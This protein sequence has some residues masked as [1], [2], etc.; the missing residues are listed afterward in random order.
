MIAPNAPRAASWIPAARPRRLLASGVLVVAAVAASGCSSGGGEARLASTGEKYFGDVTPPAGQVFTYNNGAEPQTTDPALMTGQ[1]DGRI[2]RIMFEGLTTPDPETLEPLPGQ[3]YRWEMS[4]DGLVYTFHM[5]QGLRWSDGTP[6]DARDFVWSWFRVLAPATASRYASVL[7]PIKNAER[8]NKGEVDATQVGIA[9]PDDSTLVVT[10]Q[11]PTPYFLFLTQFYTYLPTPKHVVEKH[12]DRWTQPQNVAGNGPFN[13]TFWRQRDRFEFVKNPGYWD[14]ANVKLDRLIVFCVEDLNTSTNLYKAG[15]IDWNPSGYIPSQFIPYM[16]QFADYR[17]GP[18]QGTYFYSV[19]VTAPPLDNRWVRKALNHAIDREAISRD[20][21][22]SSRDPWGNWPPSGYPGYE[23]P[24][25]VTYDPDY[26]RECLAK[27]GYPGGKGM[28]KITILFNTSEDHRRIAEAIQIMW[29]EVLG[30][31]VELE[32]K[33]WGSY[34]S[35]CF[36][37]KYDVARRSWIGDY[38]DPNTFMQCFATGDGNNRTGWGDPRY[39]GLLRK[40]AF[41]LDPPARMKLMAQAEAILLDESPVLPIYHYS[42]N[43][44]V[45]PYVR[46]IHRT[47]LDTHPMKSVWID[48][49]WRAREAELA[50]GE[51]PR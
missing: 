27:A 24:P 40:A 5:R 35:A 9:A 6:L 28:R 23:R 48:H 17:K 41:E 34:L 16:R 10:L 20:L 2:A 12:G 33:E 47:A 32:N 19:N 36:D 7:Y 4:D 8:Y 42:T 30:I 21:L 31:E 3:A 18:Y 13:L 44:L 49:D 1:P 14:A 15:V 26:A 39:D 51:D 22:K 37:L 25:G 46:G 45:K 11:S 29:R 38:L 43:E 50:R